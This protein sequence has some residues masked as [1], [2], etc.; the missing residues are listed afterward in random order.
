[1]AKDKTLSEALKA[2][3]EGGYVP[4]HMPGH[5]R[6]PEFGALLGLESMDVTE[7]DGFDDLH[8]ASGVLKRINDVAAETYGVRASR[9][10][11]GGSTCG[12]LASVR[13]LTKRGDVALIA[14]NCHSS[15]YNAA[16][17]CG[18]DA[19]YVAPSWLPCGFYG[20]LSPGDVEE[21]LK[22]N[23]GVKLVVITSPTY[24]GVISDVAGI[25]DA[26]KRYG[27]RLIVDEAHG[28]HLGFADFERSAREQG[29]DVVV[30][31]LHKTLPALTQ[32]AILHV[33]AN[34]VDLAAIDEQ[35][36]VFETSSPSYPLMASIEGCINYLRD[37]SQISKWASA[38]SELR[39]DLSGLKGFSLYDGEGAFKFDK[40]KLT[41]VSHCEKSG[42]QLMRELREK[43]GVELEMAGT[44]YALAMCGAG[45]TPE[46]Y[47]KLKEALFE[48]CDGKFASK[49][50]G[51]E[52]S[53]EQSP[54]K[55]AENENTFAKYAD[56][57]GGARMAAHTL[58]NVG[59]GALEKNGAIR[60]PELPSKVMSA[61]EA[62]EAA[63]EIVPFEE[64]AGRIAAEDIKAY[65]PGCPVI[66]KGERVE[67][68][69]LDT[70]LGLFECGVSVYGARGQ[71]PQ[72]MAVVA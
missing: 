17:I 63:Y 1:M 57:A 66:V 36:A 60:R 22:K 64:A 23:E 43:Y 54:Q 68:E 45:D 65:P 14:R 2:H 62:R 27:A 8:R 53:F 4:F 58:R 38:V 37:G 9:I 11:V 24:E 15:V 28:A 10:L 67:Q 72:N 5:K 39:R 21:A 56:G 48:L 42:A 30:N 41:L 7:I 31:S 50:A 26:C 33:C 47:A 44:N 55:Y 40:T 49:T 29:A 71:F 34:G 46:M 20:S 32:C 25:A 12:V 52:E 70:L 69:T 13:A 51:D 61:A 6:N 3:A 19:R 59:D 18:L 35:L 16:E